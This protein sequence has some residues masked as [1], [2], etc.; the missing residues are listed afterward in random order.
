[1]TKPDPKLIHRDSLTCWSW[2]E[3]DKSSF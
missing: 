1:L 2:A 3:N